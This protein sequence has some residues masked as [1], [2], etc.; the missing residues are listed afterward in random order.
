MGKEYYKQ[1]KL[2]Q[3]NVVIVVEIQ[4][5]SLLERFE[6][7]A[8]LLDLEIIEEKKPA[9]DFGGDPK[10]HAHQEIKQEVVFAIVPDNLLTVGYT[11]ALLVV[12]AIQLDQYIKT[13]DNLGAEKLELIHKIPEL[14]VTGET[15]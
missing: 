9:V 14:A 2:K 1:K 3:L 13:L 11:F 4:I 10:I 8:D 12:A 7:L 6:K 5:E 15:K